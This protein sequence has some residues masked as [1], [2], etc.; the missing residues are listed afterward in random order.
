MGLLIPKE[1]YK[2]KKQRILCRLA[3]IGAVLLLVGTF[4]LPS[5]IAPPTTGDVRG[6]DTNR[7]AQLALVLSQPIAY[8]GVWFDNFSSTL[9]NF[10]MGPD[11]LGLWDI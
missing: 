3:I 7:A 1:K 9:L 5:F 6:G 2:T 4:I 11:D 8:L 10:T